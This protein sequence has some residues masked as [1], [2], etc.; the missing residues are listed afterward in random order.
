M[1]WLRSSSCE[2]AR[3]LAALAPDRSLSEVEARLLSRHVARCS[4][5]E[6]FARSI[7]EFTD[8]LRETAP[9]VPEIDVS[10]IL[11][12]R[13]RRPRRTMKLPLV[14]LTSAAAGVLIASVVLQERSART[15]FPSTQ[16]TV[17][18]QAPAESEVD[19]LRQFRNLSLARST[20]STPP[21]GQPGIYL[22]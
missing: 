12:R 3:F 22:G 15:V 7:A 20:D 21:R 11:E 16:P 14:A 5:C 18:V 2:R 10:V 4:S 19:V 6:A 9:A 8:E 1:T 17:V 13:W